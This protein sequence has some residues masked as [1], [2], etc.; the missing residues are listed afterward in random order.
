ML[1]YV[2]DGADDKGG[3]RGADGGRKVGGALAGGMMLWRKLVLA[4]QASRTRAEAG[5][6]CEERRKRLWML[7]ARR[8]L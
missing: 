7:L 2:K 5:R 1:Y 6:R 3:S 4:V 8:T